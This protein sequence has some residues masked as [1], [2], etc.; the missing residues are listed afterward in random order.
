MEVKLRI[1]KL[2]LNYSTI[3]HIPGVIPLI[4]WAFRGA[5][6]VGA[7]EYR[8]TGLME[9]EINFRSSRSYRHG[10]SGSFDKVCD[11]K[12]IQ[13]NG[14]AGYTSGS[15]FY[16]ADL[17]YRN[18]TRPERVQ[19]ASFVYDGFR[20][21]VLSDGRYYQEEVDSS[22]IITNSL[23][24]TGLQG[25]RSMLQGKLPQKSVSTRDVSRQVFAMLETH[26]DT[27]EFLRAVRD[28]SRDFTDSIVHTESSKRALRRLKD[29]YEFVAHRVQT[30]PMH[31]DIDLNLSSPYW[32]V[33]TSVST[34]GHIYEYPKITKFKENEYVKGWRQS[35]TPCGR[36]TSK[37]FAIGPKWLD[38]VKKAYGRVF[39]N[40]QAHSY[41]LLDIDLSNPEEIIGEVLI[42][43]DR[44]KQGCALAILE[45]LKAG[46]RYGS[47]HPPSMIVSAHLVRTDPD[48]NWRESLTLKEG[49]ERYKEE[50]DIFNGLP[51]YGIAGEATIPP[52][53]RY[54]FLTKNAK[55]YR[56]K[57]F[58][59][60]RNP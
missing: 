25:L 27:C 40:K 4:A 31:C 48:S 45:Y 49:M 8:E 32:F 58:I 29:I 14:D 12:T 20:F 36:V 22:Q 7:K 19:L 46:R 56:I 47:E 42:P 17:I 10:C 13:Q 28:K 35:H 57:K 43:Y 39:S 24:Y 15:R 1:Q 33:A 21:I 9:P 2:G 11:T 60:R 52:F 3:T 55:T 26:V 18:N 51:F 38:V 34:T 41:T 16:H 6:S 23:A 5:L 59:N 37:Q 44:T 54:Y 50:R 53:W 30:G